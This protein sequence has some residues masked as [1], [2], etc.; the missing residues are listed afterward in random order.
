MRFLVGSFLCWLGF[1]DWYHGLTCIYCLRRGCE[2]KLPLY[3]GDE[4]DT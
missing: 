2:Q 4:D 1:H 3:E